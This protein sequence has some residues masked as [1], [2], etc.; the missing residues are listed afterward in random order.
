MLDLHVVDKSVD[1]GTVKVSWCLSPEGL[2]LLAKRK[3]YHP[4]ILISVIPLDLQPENALDVVK[5]HRYLFNLQDLIGFVPMR[6]PGKVALFATVVWIDTK[7]DGAR[8]HR[9]IEKNSK[10][11]Y[12][13]QLMMISGVGLSVRK[14]AGQEFYL[15]KAD[16]DPENYGYK[17]LLTLE[18]RADVI[19]PDGI[20]AKEPSAWEKKWV[21]WLFKEKACDQCNFRRR[22]IFAYSLQ[23]PIFVLIYCW[24]I[25]GLTFL[26]SITSLSISLLPLTRPLEADTANIDTSDEDDLGIRIIPPGESHLRYIFLLFTPF[27]VGSLVSLYIF[28][29]NTVFITVITFAM[30]LFFGIIFGCEAKRIAKKRNKKEEKSSWFDD[31]DE[32]EYLTCTG[33]GSRYQ[34]VGDL[35]RKH[36]TVKLRLMDLKSQ[37]CRP[38]MG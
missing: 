24:R 33:S 36:R 2:E 6:Y 7:Y 21:N 25:V 38:F 35:P 20:F 22:R 4:K 34:N 12:K 31:E 27:V 3:V 1:T 8:A 30:M 18:A 19:V 14:G 17:D 15:L 23:I 37:V 26:L 11:E 29:S 28:A 13:Y 16:S 9:L 32:V 10:N 5:E